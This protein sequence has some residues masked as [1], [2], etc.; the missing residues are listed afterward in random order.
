MWGIRPCLMSTSIMKELDCLI[1]RGN[2]KWLLEMFSF[3]IL[4]S[5]ENPIIISL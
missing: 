3:M 5:F 2:V 4:L 1:K